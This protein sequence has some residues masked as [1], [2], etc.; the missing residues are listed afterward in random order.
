MGLKPHCYIQILLYNNSRKKN[1]PSTLKILLEEEKK[2]TKKEKIF[3][4]VERGKEE[5]NFFIAEALLEA[6]EEGRLHQWQIGFPGL[7]QSLANSETPSYKTPEGTEA[8]VE[9]A[10]ETLADFWRGKI[11]DEFREKG[12]SHEELDPLG[13]GV[14]LSILP[15]VLTGT[16]VSEAVADWVDWK[17]SL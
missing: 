4:E 3:H 12:L 8:F 15:D 10:W 11:L 7:C 5:G 13:E 6:E 1:K 9:A 14:E 2:M 16:P 17:R